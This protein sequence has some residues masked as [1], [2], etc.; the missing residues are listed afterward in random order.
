[1]PGRPMP[2]GPMPRGIIMEAEEAP[3]DMEQTGMP[4]GEMNYD[5]VDD[6]KHKTLDNAPDME[7]N[8]IMDVGMP[9]GMYTDME[10][11]AEQEM[12]FESDSES[13]KTENGSSFAYIVR[14]GD[15]IDKIMSK[16]GMTIEQFAECNKME[17]ILLQP[18]ITVIIPM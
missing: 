9:R 18:G 3:E 1:M 5:G 7:M 4:N 10:S 13:Y 11:E 12:S 2:D 8:M 15:S 16:F 14:D 6:L 17:D